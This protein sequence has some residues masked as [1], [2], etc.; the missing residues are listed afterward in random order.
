[1]GQGA[2]LELGDDLLDDDL[3]DDGV[4]AVR[5]VGLEQV[6]DRVRGER[7]VAVGREQLAEQRPLTLRNSEGRFRSSV[8]IPP[9]SCRQGDCSCHFMVTTFE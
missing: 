7:V 1:M 6:K 5:L 2:I 4:L 8:A 3:L 9:R